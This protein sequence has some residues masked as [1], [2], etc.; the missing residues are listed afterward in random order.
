MSRIH[1]GI[2]GCSSIADRTMIPAI[3]SV[4]SAKL[5]MIGSRSTEKAKRFARKFSCDNYGDYE[6]VLDNKDVDA[7]YISLPPGLSEKWAIKSASAGKHIICEKP[8]AVSYESAK[9]MVTACRK[10]NVR[11]LEGFSFRFHPQHEKV[12]KIIH[13]KS[14]SNVFSFSSSYGF[15]LSHSGNNFRFQKKLGGGV[16]NDV[17][18]YIICASRM[19]FD[20]KPLSIM[21]SLSVDKKTGVDV[22]GSLYMIYSKNR[23]AYGV[24][25][26]QSLFQSRYNLWGD[27][28]II[29]LNRAFNIRDNM[30]API[31]IQTRKQAKDL[32]LNPA[33]QSKLMIIDFCRELHKRGSSKFNYEDDL[34]VQAQVMAAARK[35]FSKRR[36]VNI[37]E[38]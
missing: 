7:V 24:F 33:N 15:Q 21:C 27:N 23:V 18:C 1:F 30:K 22:S 29:S 13:N 9:N 38:I 3:K 16:L 28:I 25:S 2:I 32:Q 12:L 35:S 36:L 4:N 10:N 14:K 20:E 31:T 19:V 6:D 8:A 17:G 37:S 5:E 11:I 34:I 26:Y